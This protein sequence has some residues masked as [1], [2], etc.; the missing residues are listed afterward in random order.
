MDSLELMSSGR[1]HDGFTPEIATALHRAAQL[2][3]ELNQLPPSAADRRDEIIHALFGTIGDRYH[4]NT[5]FRCDIGHN[6]HIGDRFLCNFNVAILD[7]A[8]VTIGDNV[9]IGPNTTICTITHSLD[10][11]QRNAGIM[12][13]Q[14]ITIGN[15]VWL[16]A[17]VTVMPGVSIGDG[18]VIGAGSLVTHDLPS[19]VLAY[20]SPCRIIRAITAADKVS[21]LALF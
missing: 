3:H 6:I 13:A 16:G 15:N 20:G 8:P 12:R 19:G 21:D 14:P 2:C 1:W 7:E 17:G 18:T 5:P 4:I 11:E 10:A 9:F